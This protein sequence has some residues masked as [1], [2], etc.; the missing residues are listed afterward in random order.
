MNENKF[1]LMYEAAR[2]DIVKLQIAMFGMLAVFCGIAL[3]LPATML[4]TFGILLFVFFIMLLLNMV[5]LR[6]HE[7]IID[8]YYNKIE[9]SLIQDCIKLKD[10][11]YHRVDPKSYKSD[12]PM[13]THVSQLKAGR[14]ID[15]TK[16]YIDPTTGK[17]APFDNKKPSYT[18]T[19]P[20]S[21]KSSTKMRGYLRKSKKSPKK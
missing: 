12:E 3:F 15:L 10:T 13:P 1:M 7:I 14:V 6:Q 8:Y 5:I 19:G 18:N 17:I 21:K 9:E 2:R 4:I 16:V 11:L 20:V